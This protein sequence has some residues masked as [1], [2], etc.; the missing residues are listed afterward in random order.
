M[1]GMEDGDA[2]AVVPPDPMVPRGPTTAEPSAPASSSAAEIHEA[3]RPSLVAVP[4]P[5]TTE[6]RVAPLQPRSAHDRR[7]EIAELMRIYGGAVRGF[8]ARVLHDS[9]LAEDVVQ[10]V[11]LQAYRDLDRLENRGAIRSWLFAIASNRCVDTIRKEVRRS[12]WTQSADE[13]VNHIKD[14]RPDQLERLDR[15][16]LSVALDE[17]LALLSP[18]VR[19]TVLMRFQTGMTYE[20]L[21]R[22]L[23]ARAE[24]L[25]LRVVRALRKLRDCL[26]RKGWTGE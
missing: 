12:R 11:F 15:A 7:T 2:A 6:A 4:T 17:C 9:T 16:Q 13:T 10:Q 24:A 19:M 23:D 14:S 3:A 22:S 20:Q 18:E 25:Q 1:N 5:S 21:S 8:C 26:E